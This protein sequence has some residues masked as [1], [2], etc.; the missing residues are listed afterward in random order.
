MELEGL[1]CLFQG[2]QGLEGKERRG[3]AAQEGEG[4]PEGNKWKRLSLSCSL[5]DPT[6]SSRS[7]LGIIGYINIPDIR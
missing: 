2:G 4:K 6:H 3:H 5:L 7:L 1:D